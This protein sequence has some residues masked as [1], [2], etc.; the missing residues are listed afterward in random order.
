MGLKKNITG[1][2][3]TILSIGLGAN[4]VQWKNNTAV[5]E[6]RNSDD[7]AFVVVRG[8]A[9]V[10]DSDLVNKKYADAL[11][12]PIIV[13]RQ[14]DTS[15][16][17]PANTAVRGFVVVTT[18]GSGAV[19]GDVLFDD[20]SSGGT[21]EILSIVEGRTL[22]ITDALAGGTVTFETDSIYIWDDDAF[23]WLKIGDIGALTGPIRE[24]RYASSSQM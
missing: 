17:I 7:T 9:P 8:L 18:A 6:A 24:V 12:K 3:G 4:K 23:L 22:A 1:I 21:M 16:S 15:A 5:M 14:A 13:S 11:E 20:G 19:I 2:L 10:G